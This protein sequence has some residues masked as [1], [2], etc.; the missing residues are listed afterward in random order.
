MKKWAVL[1][2]LFWSPAKASDVYIVL[3]IG[4]NRCGQYVAAEEAE[5]EHYLAYLVGYVSGANSESTGVRRQTG[6]GWE[7]ESTLLWLENYCRANPLKAFVAAI[8]QFR[9]E[10]TPATPQ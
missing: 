2:A 1:L 10:M 9:D 4:T 8:D 6:T 5:R 3:S 7:R